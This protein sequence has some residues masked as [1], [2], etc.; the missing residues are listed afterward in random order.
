MSLERSSV[1][2]GETSLVKGLGMQVILMFLEDFVIR[3]QGVQDR[4]QANNCKD[5]VM[6][7]WWPRLSSLAHTF[8]KCK[9]KCVYASIKMFTLATY[10]YAVQVIITEGTRWSLV[11]FLGITLPAISTRKRKAF[12]FLVLTLVLI[13]PQ[14]T[15]SS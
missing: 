11:E 15:Q 8:D 14:C 6:L 5:T 12:I 1:L 9:H 2:W 13:S 7:C 10:A 3:H 4:P